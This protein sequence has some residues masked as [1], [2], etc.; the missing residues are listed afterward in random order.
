MSRRLWIILFASFRRIFAHAQPGP[1]NIGVG[2]RFVTNG[3]V[4]RENNRRPFIVPETPVLPDKAD[5]KNP[6]ADYGEET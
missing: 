4:D 1:P 5:S 6:N 3:N 2:W